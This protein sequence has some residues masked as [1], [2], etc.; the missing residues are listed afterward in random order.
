MSTDRDFIIKQDS[1]CKKIYLYAYL[2]NE[3]V[4]KI[5]DPNFGEH[6]S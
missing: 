5:R 3:K 2:G 6:I 1:S 4:V